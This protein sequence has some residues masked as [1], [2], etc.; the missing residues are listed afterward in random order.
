MLRLTACL[1]MASSAIAQPA[2]VV[3]R[4]GEPYV[5]G[6][7]GSE[8][9]EELEGF[10]R[11]NVGLY[12]ATGRDVGVNYE[13]TDATG[14]IYLTAYVYPSAKAR[15]A[16]QRERTCREDHRGASAAIADRFPGARTVS[17]G[18]A[19]AIQQARSELSWKS[20]HEFR[21]SFKGVE[22]D[23][24]SELIVYCYVADEWQ[25]KYRVSAP[26]GA[27]LDSVDAFMSK[28]PWP[29]GTNRKRVKT[30]ATST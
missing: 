8:F 13:R 17:E 15:R 3:P 24:Q 16:T 12:D 29:R 9:P 20:R 7:S 6:V 10:R 26:A 28:G 30:R 4:S 5:H 14:L 25:L 1:M 23:V 27:K 2:S 21:T 18:P 22:Q 19:P 11:T